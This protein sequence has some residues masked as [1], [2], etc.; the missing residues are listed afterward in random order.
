LERLAADEGKLARRLSGGG[1]VYHDLGNLNFTFL[2]PRKDYDLQRQLRVILNA[3]KAVG[4]EAE[5]SGRNDILAQGRKFSGNAFYHGRHASFHHGTILIDVDLTVLAKYLNV[6]TQ[7][8][9]SKGVASVQSRVVNLRELVPALSLMAMRE[10]MVGSFLAAYGGQGECLDIKQLKDTDE[11]GTLYAKY[12][13]WDW[14]IG[15]SPK[16]DVTYE[17]RFPWGGVELGLLVS[18]GTVSEAK[19]Y[20]D[21]MEAHLIEPMAESLVGSPFERA[22]LAKRLLALSATLA[23]PLIAE[24]AEWLR[25]EVLE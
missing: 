21:A 5:F 2:V 14:R 24:L 9:S 15:K 10:A 16:F 13:S 12:S 6:P 23:A 22:H 7:K 19:I 20:S 18:G 11:F 4:I 3:V 17:A 25:N 8:M 1:A